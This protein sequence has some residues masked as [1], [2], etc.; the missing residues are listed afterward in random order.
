MLKKHQSWIGL[1]FKTSI[2]GYEIKITIKKIEKK[3]WTIFLTIKK[4]KKKQVVMKT[5]RTKWKKDNDKGLNRKIERKKIDKIKY[6]EI[7]LK[8]KTN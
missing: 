7:K 2:V 6:W 5:I 8:D 3:S 1:I 4:L